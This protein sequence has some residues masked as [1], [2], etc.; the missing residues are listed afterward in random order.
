M[1]IEPI[2]AL[3]MDAEAVRIPLIAH[4]IYR[5]DVGGLENGLVNLINRIPEDRFRHAVISLT[6]DSDFRR[7]IT[8][9]DVPVYCLDKPPG[10]S[11]R[12]QF[13]LWRLLRALRPDIVHTRNLAALECSVT[14][15]LACDAA[16]VHGEHG[17]DV[18]DLDGTNVGRQ[19]IRRLFRP[20]VHRYSSVSR[21]L[22][23]YLEDKV[24]VAPERITR[25][26]NGVDTAVFHPAAG[27]VH[28]PAADEA[29]MVFGTV[30][31]MQAVK[32]PLDLVSAF[33]LLRDMLPQR[34]ASLR[35]AMA[36]D[37]PLREEA[38]RRLEAAG[39]LEAAWLPGTRDDVP[40]VM[41]GYDV[42]VLPSLAEGISNTVLEAMASGLPVIATRVGGN[43]E[44]VEDGRTGMLVPPD[45]PRA[46]A[47]AMY[48][49]AIDPDLAQRHGATARSVAEERYGLDVMVRNYTNFY[50]SALAVRQRVGRGGSA[51]DYRTKE[52]M[53]THANGRR[54]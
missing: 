16:R 31:R 9:P 40:E 43:P 46:L 30:G 52:L 39:A 2:G 5:L 11:V 34:R 48:R 6:R 42:F 1:R 15:A 8:R 33:L 18:D 38:L 54:R 41:R 50:E 21:D 14:A 47:E 53:P 51:G 25:I 3:A 35:L 45:S 17:R 4:V 49:Y 32:A 13:K 10:N 19:R 37:G 7:R 27:K 29:T 20:F 23:V 36:G 44:L 12:T 26:C 24:R 22:A 28:A